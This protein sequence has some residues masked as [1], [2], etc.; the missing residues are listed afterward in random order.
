MKIVADTL[1]IETRE[2]LQLIRNAV[3]RLLRPEASLGHCQRAIP[4]HRYRPGCGKSLPGTRFG[5]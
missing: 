2:K 5:R 3:S 1:T 4:R